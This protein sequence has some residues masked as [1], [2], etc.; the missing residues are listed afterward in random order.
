MKKN[1]SIG[2]QI[3]TMVLIVLILLFS[4][5]LYIQ[6]VEKKEAETNTIDIGGIKI[7]K[8]TFEGLMKNINTTDIL[9]CNINQDKC[10][11]INILKGG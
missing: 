7:E 3:A 11:R 6:S 8:S 1:K 5:L 10:V 4:V 9:F 2:W